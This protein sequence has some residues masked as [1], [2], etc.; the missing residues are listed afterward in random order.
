MVDIPFIQP[1]IDQ[2]MRFVSNDA[3]TVTIVFGVLVIV[4]GLAFLGAR[5]IESD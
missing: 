4:I 2:L 1:F 5:R 3:Y